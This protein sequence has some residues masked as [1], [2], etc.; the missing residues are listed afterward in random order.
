MSGAQQSSLPNVREMV[1]VHNGFRRFFGEMP[2]LVRQAR[3][4]DR[5][6]S[7]VLADHVD[8]GVEILHDHHGREDD[9]LWPML[10]ERAQ[11]QQELIKRMQEQHAELSRRLERMHDASTTYRASTH[12]TERDA[13]AEAIDDLLVVVQEHMRDEEDNILPLC[14]Q[15][16]TAH[17]WDEMAGGDPPS[18][19]QMAA[20]LPAIEA[21]NTSEDVAMLLGSLPAPVRSVVIPL[22]VRPMASRYRRRLLATGGA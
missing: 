13:L 9:S 8:L 16:V 11:P 19:K 15:V 12:A 14:E 2:G 20:L 5:N 1:V 4:G 18:I 22:I 10:L 7:A 17:E 3:P 21:N 6:G